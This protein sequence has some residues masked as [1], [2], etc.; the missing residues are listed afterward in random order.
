MSKEWWHEVAARAEVEFDQLR[1]EFQGKMLEFVETHD[2]RV[3]NQL[4]RLE[5][6]LRSLA[7]LNA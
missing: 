3:L 7:G 6:R 4:L 5:Q 1:R 2:L